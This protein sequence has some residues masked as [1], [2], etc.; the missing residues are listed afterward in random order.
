MPESHVENAT[1]GPAVADSGERA[2]RSSKLDVPHLLARAQDHFNARRIGRA[3][4]ALRTGLSAAPDD[5][6][7]N[8]LLG[9]CLW[10]TGE[11]EKA[12][13]RFRRV[14]RLAPDDERVQFNLGHFLS[15]K[16]RYELALPHLQRSCELRPDAHH[17]WHAFGKAQ[18]ASGAALAAESSLQRALRLEPGIAGTHYELGLCRMARDDLAGALAAMERAVLL[19]PGNELNALIAH[20]VRGEL[21]ARGTARPGGKRI[22]L[23][24]NQ[25]LHISILGPVLEQLQDR[26]HVRI[27]RDPRLVGQFRP[28]VVIVADAQADGLRTFAPA[29]KYVYVRHGLITKNHAFSAAAKCDF[30]AG[31][32]SPAV[33]DL[34]VQHGAFAPENVWV[35]GYVQMDPL[36]RGA[37]LPC[38]VSLPAQRPVVLFA[39][40]YNARLSAAPMLRARVVELI[41]GGRD[42]IEIVI[43]P[44]PITWKMEPR[45]IETW[46]GLAAQH[47]HVHL[48]ADPAAD[49]MALLQRADVLISDACSMAFAFL[50]LD[51]PIIL[52]TNPERHRDPNYDPVGIEWLWRDL[53]EELF[54]AEQLPAAVGRALSQ[55]Q[56]HAE[57]RAHYRELVFGELTDG[58]AAE[59]I[60]A[61][62]DAL[63]FHAP[64]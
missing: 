2:R 6:G 5:P 9:M 36:F 31:V 28:D 32:S 4:S 16:H 22:V 20:G 24:L 45:W 48:V 33:R 19:D 23:H 21:A 38:P 64:G 46:R 35:T 56:Q 50:A 57:R 7:L 49:A 10:E 60:A 13:R 11:Q 14:A 37:P 27:T 44:H 41:G 43:K 58:R 40:T 1:E 18:R 29:A 53:G 34:A 3:R 39:P 51:R 30:L 26:H 61:H 12:E 47:E 62:I 17:H 15:R 59:R 42:N 8:L 55:P 52:L 63:E 25:H 54:D